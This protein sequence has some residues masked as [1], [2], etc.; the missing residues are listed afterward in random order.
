MLDRFEKSYNHICIFIFSCGIEMASAFEIM[1]REKTE[2]FV[3][4]R[5]YHNS[6]WLGDERGLNI[7]NRLINV[8][9]TPIPIN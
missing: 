7:I 2:L 6:W 1:P 4:H 9:M 8:N 5:Q 3:P